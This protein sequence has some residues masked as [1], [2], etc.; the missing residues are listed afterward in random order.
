MMKK[1]LE[2]I[3]FSFFLLYW[4]NKIG[5]NF[6]LIVPINIITL[7]IVYFFNIPGLLMLVLLYFH[8]I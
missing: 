8:C 3:I 6:N 1:I 4:F 2:R 5:I 7:I